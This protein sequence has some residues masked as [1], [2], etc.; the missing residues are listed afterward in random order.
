MNDGKQ[1]TAAVKATN[2]ERFVV[3]KAFLRQEASEAVILFFAPLS[4]IL[5]VL[6]GRTAR[7]RTDHEAT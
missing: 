1:E 7:D 4:F 6:T 5:R 3:D 2:E